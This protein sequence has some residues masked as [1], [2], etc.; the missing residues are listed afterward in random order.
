MLVL[1]RILYFWNQT[2]ILPRVA[3]FYS[4]NLVIYFTQYQ[5]INQ[6]KVLIVVVELHSYTG[7]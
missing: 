7:F 1:M 3:E 6:F 5:V 2:I 4:M